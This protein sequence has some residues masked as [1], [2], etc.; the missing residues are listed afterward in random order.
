MT[1]QENVHYE[2]VVYEAGVWTKGDYCADVHDG[3]AVVLRITHPEVD[4]LHI[5]QQGQHMARVRKL[6]GEREA[7][8]R[9]R[10]TL[11]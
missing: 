1:L 3:R 8:R 11:E 4:P 5:Q 7:T 6:T 2:T 9:A 10:N